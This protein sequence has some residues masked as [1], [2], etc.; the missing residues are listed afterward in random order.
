[1]SI[2]SKIRRLINLYKLSWVDDRVT[3]LSGEVSALR[4]ELITLFDKG[5]KALSDECAALRNER[6]RLCNEITELRSKQS[7]L[8][9]RTALLAGRE[10]V[11]LLKSSLE[12]PFEMID[13]FQEWK[14]RNPIPAEPLITVCS[15]T[16]NRARLLTE[17]CI[18]SIL[19][20]TYKRME[21]I[22]VGDG[23]TDETER[24]VA[25][26]RDPRLKFINL[27]ERGRYPTDYWRRWMVA[28][29]V[30]V[31]HALTL[32]R[33]DY[34]THLDDDDEHMPDRLEKLVAFAQ[35]E[36]CDLAWHPFW[37]EAAPDQWLLNE[38][39]NF[40]LAQVTTSAVFYRAWLAKIPWD[41]RAHR[42]MEPGDWNRF[43]RI[44]YVGA[45]CRRYPEPLLRHYRERNRKHEV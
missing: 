4:S 23:C 34:I 1:M 5:A 2:R 7:E 10:E 12:V 6:D 45:V 9:S 35:A 28:G 33:G 3:T 25:K 38:A 13:E 43:R 30:A 29:T 20:Q 22:I 42:L 31:N 24:L 41:V 26:I 8:E 17:R 27:P 11:D 39:Q 15:A 16:F 21:V 18:P 32:A 19:G 44:K 14:A 37:F 36:Q 40:A